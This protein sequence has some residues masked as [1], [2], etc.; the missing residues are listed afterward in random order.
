[1]KTVRRVLKLLP[2]AFLMR[3]WLDRRYG[4]KI[5]PVPGGV[6]ARCVFAVL[7]Y[8]FTAAL[9][10]RVESDCRLL[11]YFL[12]YGRMSKFVRMAYGIQRGNAELDHGFVG[13][14]RSVMPYGLVLWWDAEDDRISGRTLAVRR[15]AQTAQESSVRRNSCE[16]RQTIARMDRIEA[17]TLRLLIST[18]GGKEDE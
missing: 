18:A 6:I 16:D 17:M 3:R 1:M 2:P 13:V 15:K 12:P 5:P 8:A 9:N 11:K 14:L 7:P 4:I 10:V